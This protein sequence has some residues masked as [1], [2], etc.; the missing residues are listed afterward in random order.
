[1]T[2]RLSD[3]AIAR[4]ADT[5][6]SIFGPLL[7][8][9]GATKFN[10]YHGPDGRFTNAEGNTRGI[11]TEGY[12]PPKEGTGGHRRLTAWAKNRGW[13]EADGPVHDWHNKRMADLEEQKKRQE[14]E[15]AAAAAKP[16]EKARP[17]EDKP[18]EPAKEKAKVAPGDTGVEHIPMGAAPGTPATLTPQAEKHLNS[19]GYWVSP[20]SQI[21]ISNVKGTVGDKESH[22]VP[23]EGHE[24]VLKGSDEIPLKDYQFF[25]YHPWQ[26]TTEGIKKDRSR[27]SIIEKSTGMGIGYGDT[28]DDAAATAQDNIKNHVVDKSKF[29]K[30]MKENQD[31]FADK[32]KAAYERSPEENRQI[33][34]AYRAAKDQGYIDKYGEEIVKQREYGSVADHKRNADDSAVRAGNKA[35]DSVVSSVKAEDLADMIADALEP[36]IT[37]KFNPW[38]DDAGRFKSSEGNTSGLG[39]ASHRPP[40]DQTSGKRRLEAWAK[41]R[42][43]DE[44][45][46]PVHEWHQAEEEK[47]KQAALEETRRLQ[48][49]HYKTLHE[50]KMAEAAKERSN[51]AIS[52]RQKQSLE[53]KGHWVGSAARTFLIT[54]GGWGDTEPTAVEVQGRPVMIKGMEEIPMFLHKE[55]SRATL[56]D[57]RTGMS[58]FHEYGWQGKT[59]EQKT[60]EKAHE[61]VAENGIDKLKKILNDGASDPKRTKHI[62]EGYA[63]MDPS[64]LEPVVKPATPPD[65]RKEGQLRRGPG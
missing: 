7:V 45:K 23:F 60:M 9:P 48:D 4:I 33:I 49:E 35:T 28:R 31:K 37:A 43:W 3:E 50:Q 16:R 6:A 57:A 36:Y 38:H 8:E 19:K 55:G 54:H 32:I 42:G 61:F 63:A 20:K 1:M 30:A 34:E 10:P 51:K 52:N 24:V 39:T 56:S 44:S 65:E 25:A 46:G 27:W 18:K 26:G 62:D 13:T 40:G 58:V 29:D 21:F 11:G 53:E 64:K 22:A 59:A 2:Q 14:A 15:A 12:K 41:N 5:V 47:K 17:V